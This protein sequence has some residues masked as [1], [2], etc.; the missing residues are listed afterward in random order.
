[1]MEIKNPIFR[2]CIKPWPFILI[3]AVESYTYNTLRVEV[4]FASKRLIRFKH[5]IRRINERV[6]RQYGSL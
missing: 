2:I 5:K 3:I 6:K 1:M 4:G